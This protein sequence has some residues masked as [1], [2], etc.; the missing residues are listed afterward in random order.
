[1]KICMHIFESIQAYA[2]RYAEYGQVI[3]QAFHVGY[4]G[5]FEFRSKGTLMTFD[6]CV[7]YIPVLLANK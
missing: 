7:I 5:H 4:L 2:E 3:P 1:M 6:V